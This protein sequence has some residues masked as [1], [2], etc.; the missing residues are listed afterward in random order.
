MQLKQLKHQWEKIEIVPTYENI[1]LEANILSVNQSSQIHIP[2]N[3]LNFSEDTEYYLYFHNMIYLEENLYQDLDIEGKRMRLR[4]LGSYSGQKN[5]YMV[6]IPITPEL[7]EKGYI[8]ICFPEE[9]T[10]SLGEIELRALNIS[11][12]PEHYQKRMESTLQDLTIKGNEITG[13][14]QT[15]TD[16][17][18]FM[19]IPYST[20][21]RCY[22]NGNEAPVLNANMGFCAVEIPAGEY[23]V[24]WKYTTPGLKSGFI[25][26]FISCSFFIILLLKRK[27]A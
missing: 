14:L 7:A 25:L 17:L 18:L 22:L 5:T 26:S 23:S 20:G 19:S 2:L 9:G 13:N 11:S 27:M 21:W 10:Y 12:Y 4:P 1:H 15:A 24:V 6:K 16:K 3:G 8:A